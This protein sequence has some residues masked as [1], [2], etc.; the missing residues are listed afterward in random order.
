MQA[1]CVDDH[2]S[3]GRPHAMVASQISAGPAQPNLPRLQTP[4]IPGDIVAVLNTLPLSTNVP[5]VIK[6]E[7]YTEEQFLVCAFYPRW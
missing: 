2:P 1:M 6:G 5:N 3:A 4:R 7:P